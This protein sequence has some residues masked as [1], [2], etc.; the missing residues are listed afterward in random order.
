MLSRWDGRPGE[1]GPW[2]VLC[3]PVWIPVGITYQLLTFCIFTELVYTLLISAFTAW[4]S[5][6]IWFSWV[7][8]RWPI[9]TNKMCCFEQSWKIFNCIAEM[10]CTANFVTLC[11]DDLSVVTTLVSTCIGAEIIAADFIKPGLESCIHREDAG[12]A[13]PDVFSNK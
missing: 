10:N 2:W 3:I 11:P 7:I 8:P 13:S 4:L 1:M 6:F 5:F 9:V 12:C